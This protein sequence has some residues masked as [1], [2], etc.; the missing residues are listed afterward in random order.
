MSFISAVEQYLEL[1]STYPFVLQV[2]L[3][4][5]LFNSLTAITFVATIYLIRGRKDKEERIEE[6][7][8]PKQKNFIL[9]NLAAEDIL[10]V[11]NVLADYSEQI[12]KLNNRTY[13]PLITAFEDIVKHNGDTTEFEY[14]F[15]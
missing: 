7:L 14:H 5:I 12:G 10:L 4:F 3:Y 9:Q 15:P 8:Y 1:I 2:A 6:E 11:E 13:L